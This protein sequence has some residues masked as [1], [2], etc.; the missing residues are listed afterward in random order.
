LRVTSVDLGVKVLFGI[1]SRTDGKAL[2]AW[3]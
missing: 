2:W 3:K 1:G